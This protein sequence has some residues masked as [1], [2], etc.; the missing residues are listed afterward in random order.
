[1]LAAGQQQGIIRGRSPLIELTSARRALCQLVFSKTKVKLRLQQVAA[2]F[3]KSCGLCSGHH[4]ATAQP[5]QGR[6]HHR[7]DEAEQ[8]HLLP[9]RVHGGAAEPVAQ[10][11]G[12]AGAADDL[13]RGGHGVQ[14]HLKR[15]DSVCDVMFNL[16]GSIAR[17]GDYLCVDCSNLARHRLVPSMS[18]RPNN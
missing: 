12:Q 6:G 4:Q 7:Q 2:G 18:T 16:G 11:S 5:H 14:V 10:V 9:D 1:M 3:V 8:D 13:S 15:E 17:L